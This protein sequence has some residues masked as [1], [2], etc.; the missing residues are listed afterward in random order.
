MDSTLPAVVV[1]KAKV[2]SLVSIQACCCCNMMLDC[3]CEVCTKWLLQAHL[4]HLIE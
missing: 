3:I 4:V 1:Q 2:N